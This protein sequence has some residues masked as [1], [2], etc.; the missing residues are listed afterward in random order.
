M[1]HFSDPLH[2]KTLSGDLI[3][4]RDDQRRE[5][6]QR[7]IYRLFDIIVSIIL[8]PIFLPLIAISAI[9]VKLSSPAGPVFFRQVR[10]GLNGKPFRIYKLR[11]MVPKAEE[12]KRELPGYREEQGAGF[13]LTQD[14]RVLPIG[15]VLR[16]YYI[17]EM[18]Q[19]FNVLRGDMA[20]VGPRACSHPLALYEP[21]QMRRLCVKPGLT[22]D[23]QVD[24]NKSYDFHKRCVQDLAYVDA[25]S[26]RH[27]VKIVFRTAFVCLFLHNGK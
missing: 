19:I 9:A 22:G 10:Y 8:L 26:L 15:R 3:S 20:I 18:P 6:V 4:I 7:A 11:T 25:K 17:D 24:R 12:L 1:S 23:W 16:R 13:K 27:D 14:P 2:S 5:S 21:W